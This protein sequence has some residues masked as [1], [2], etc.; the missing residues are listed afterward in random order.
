MNS[1]TVY[2]ESDNQYLLLKNLFE[3]MKIRFVDSEE[4]TESQKQILADRLK[5]AEE[6]NVKSR[7]ESREIFTKCFK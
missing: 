1:I 5:S 4:L 6:G 7:I 2:P 3:E